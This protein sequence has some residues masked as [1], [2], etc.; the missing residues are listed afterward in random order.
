MEAIY[1][2][3]HGEGADAAMDYTG[4]PQPRVQMVRS[5]KIYGRACFVGEGGDTTFDVSRDII[6][7]QLTVMGSWTMSTVSLGEVANYVVDRKIPL[8]RLITHRFRLE[9]AVEAYKVFESGE[10]GKVAFIWPS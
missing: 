9:E 2:L 6:H 8:A 7:K 1:G 5:A 3:T 4:L 10:T